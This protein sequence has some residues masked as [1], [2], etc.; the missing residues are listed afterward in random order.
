MRSLSPTTMRLAF[1]RALQTDMGPLRPIHTMVA[2]ALRKPIRQSPW[3]RGR[4]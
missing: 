4:R 2:E 3:R 1:E